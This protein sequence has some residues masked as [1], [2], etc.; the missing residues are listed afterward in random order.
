MPLAGPSMALCHLLVPTRQDACPQ[1][2]ASPFGRLD[3]LHDGGDVSSARGV[4]V[5]DP[6]KQPGEGRLA[7]KAA[8]THRPWTAEKRRT[9]EGELPRR[10]EDESGLGDETGMVWVEVQV[11]DLGRSSKVEPTGAELG[12]YTGSPKLGLWTMGSHCDPSRQ[13]ARSRL[14][15]ASGVTGGRHT[16][17]SWKPDFLDKEGGPGSP[18]RTLL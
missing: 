17:T 15:G 2:A 18:R 8:G 12:C 10:R 13:K 11:G 14:S 9:G 1:E 16:C 5:E 6:Q 4:S 7:G 3:W